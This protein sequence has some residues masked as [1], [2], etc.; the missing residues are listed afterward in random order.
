MAQA[1]LHDFGA[2]LAP[3]DEGWFVV[4]VRDAEWS[5][6]EKFGSECGFESEE[7]R[8]PGLGINVTVLEPGQPNCLYH[9]ESQQE[10]FLVL[11]GECRLLVEGEERPLRAWDF[12][13]CPPCTE[14]VL[15]GAGEAP[16]VLLMA[17]ARTDSEQLLYPVSELAASYGASAEQET[18]AP[19]Q[20]YAPFAP[21]VRGRPSYWQRLPWA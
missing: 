1:R 15:V 6:S 9:A 4:N 8:F 16:C 20:A 19:K 13:H 11:S 7:V 3:V 21:P 2:G 17:G 12:F 5:T 14:H 18:P 10:A